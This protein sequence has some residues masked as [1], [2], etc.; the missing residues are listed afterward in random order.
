MLDHLHS[1]IALV[2]VGGAGA[3]EA[4]LQQA[5]AASA[6]SQTGWFEPDGCPTPTAT[7]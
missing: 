5:I 6:S 2:L 4:D 3:A 1:D 7:R